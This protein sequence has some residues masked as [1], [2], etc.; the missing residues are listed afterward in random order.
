[1]EEGLVE[2]KAASDGKVTM[3]GWLNYGEQE[4]PNLYKT[5]KAKGLKGEQPTAA[6]GRDIIYLGHDQAPP[7][8]QQ[9]V[10]FDF[11]KQRADVLVS[12]N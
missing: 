8:Y 7:A 3:S 12:T 4:V 11:N 6:N 9:P 1:V 5:G 10:L 2:E